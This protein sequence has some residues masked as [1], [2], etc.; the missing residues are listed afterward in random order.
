MELMVDFANKRLGG[1]VLTDGAVQEEI[2]FCIFPELVIARLLCA[3][4]NDN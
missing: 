4:L 3:P 2:M 1:G